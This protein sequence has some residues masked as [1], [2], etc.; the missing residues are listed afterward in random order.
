MYLNVLISQV[1]LF[2]EYRSN[3]SFIR[4][5]FLKW[6]RATL[7]LAAQFA[8]YMKN[9]QLASA[10]SLLQRYTSMRVT[11]RVVRLQALSM[12]GMNARRTCL[13]H[14]A[15]RASRHRNAVFC[16]HRAAN[17]HCIHRLSMF[18]RKLKLV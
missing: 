16:L 5:I 12:W 3:K 14:W 2:I 11:S 9:R 18:M 15:L 1:S 7:Y 13:T 8:L 10:F 4:R 17:W 6:R